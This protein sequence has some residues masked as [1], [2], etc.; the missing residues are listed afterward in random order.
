MRNSS[1]V[2]ARGRLDRF[3]PDADVRERH[4]IVVH[5]PASL[6][7]DTAR[8][9]DMR[10]VPL[11]GLIFWLRERLLGALRANTAPR[12]LVDE[13]LSLGWGV[14]EEVKG[15]YF[16]AGA[17]CQPWRADVLF[18]AVPPDDFAAYA[19]P[20]RVKIVWTL[21]AEPLGPE[22]T[23]FAT[24]TRAAGTDAG[25]RARFRRYWRWAGIGIVSIRR[26]L[27]PAIR[28]EAERRWRQTTRATT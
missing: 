11:V 3:L 27:L 5:A 28:H 21:E 6:A 22:S 16:C 12:G 9:F 18:T 2:A 1:A 20:D 14:L 8:S 13:T 19:Q 7:F 25:A 10:S 26:L 15:R 23:R 4:E 17:V 24:E